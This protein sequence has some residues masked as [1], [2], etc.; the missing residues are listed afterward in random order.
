MTRPLWT[1][2]STVPTK[3]ELFGFNF[4]EVANK[5]SRVWMPVILRQ[6]RGGGSVDKKWN[7]P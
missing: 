2:V 1:N 6:G 3:N 7:I 5:N 4:P